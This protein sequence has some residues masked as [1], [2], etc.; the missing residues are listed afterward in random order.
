MLWLCFATNL[1]L[2]LADPIGKDPA[3]STSVNNNNNNN[4]NNKQNNHSNM[5]RVMGMKSQ[6]VDERSQQRNWINS[7]LSKTSQLTS[8]E[9]EET[10]HKLQ[11]ARKELRSINKELRESYA[12]YDYLEVSWGEKAA[13]ANT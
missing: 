8:I 2:S 3:P 4:S 5:N 7:N 10:R 9:V 1:S 11:Q 6:A 13:F 12:N